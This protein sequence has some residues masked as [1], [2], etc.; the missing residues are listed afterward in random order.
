MKPKT[1]RNALLVATIAWC[2]VLAVEIVRHHVHPMTGVVLAGSMLGLVFAQIG[3][4]E[5]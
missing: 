1:V 5:R 4:V 3:M 2:V